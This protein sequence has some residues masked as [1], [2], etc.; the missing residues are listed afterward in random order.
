MKSQI[1]RW[2]KNAAVIIP[3][4]LLIGAKVDVGSVVDVSVV[5]GK[6][7]IQALGNTEKIFPFTE[8]ELFRALTPNMAHADELGD[9][10]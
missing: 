10:H 2:D 9:S 4:K 6:I 1:K 5:D 3:S 7:V 8:A